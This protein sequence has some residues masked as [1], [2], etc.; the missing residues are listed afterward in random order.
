AEFPAGPLGQTGQ[1]AVATGSLQPSTLG[2][3]READM[4]RQ[5][6]ALAGAGTGDGS[7]PLSQG[8][9]Q[10]GFVESVIKHHLAIIAHQIDL[11]RQSHTGG[12]LLADQASTTTAT[13][14][15]AVHPPATMMTQS[16]EAQTQRFGPFKAIE[17]GASGGLTPHQQQC[18][19]DLI[20]RYNRKTGAS[21]R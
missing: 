20:Q 12:R 19:A 13:P 4:A 14:A 15:S 2:K 11:L 7:P 5:T 8:G 16:A 9:L 17:R 3:P 21:K 10:V 18:L 6:R 1:S